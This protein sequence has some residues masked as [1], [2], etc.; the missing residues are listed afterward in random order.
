METSNDRKNTTEL[1]SRVNS[2]IQNIFST[3]LLSL[4]VHFTWDG[5]KPG[6]YAHKNLHQQRWPVLAATIT[7]AET[8]HP[9][10]HCA[11][12]HCL[13]PL[14]IQQ[15]LMNV[16]RYKLFHTFSSENSIPHLFFVSI[17]MSDAI[18]SDFPSATISCTATKIMEYRQKGSASTARPPTP[19]LDIMGQHN[20]IGGITFSGPLTHLKFSISFSNSLLN[21]ML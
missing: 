8:H 4:G 10:P 19:T 12:I 2:Q 17:F 1:F 11:N 7:T 14:N 6:C 5:Q 15:M 13:I 21:Q 20:K 9:P 16:N 3:Q 18:V